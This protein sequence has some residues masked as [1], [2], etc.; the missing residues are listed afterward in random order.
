MQYKDQAL[1]SRDL[2]TID[3]HAPVDFDPDRLKT[4][5]PD[6]EA[7][8]QLFAELEFRQ[9][10]HEYTPQDQSVERRYAAILDAAG[11]DELV[12]RLE[13]SMRFALDTETTALDPM[14]ARLVGLSFC[15]SPG[16]AWYLPVGHNYLGAPKQLSLETVLARLRPVMV[17]PNIEKIGQNIKY[18]WMVLRRHGLDLAA[19]TFDTMVASY[20]IDP[21]K[22][23]HGLDQ[24]A[25]DYLG[26]KNITYAEVAGKGKAAVTFDQVILEK[27]IPYACEDADMT[28]AAHDVFV[29]LLEE[30]GLTELM[31][32]VEM[33]LL[34]VL[35]AMEMTGVCVDRKRLRDLSKSFAGQLDILEGQI[36]GLAGETFNINSSQQ[37][38]HILFEK[39]NLPVQKRPR[40]RP[41]TPP[42]WRCSRPWPAVTNY[43]PWCCATGPWPSSN[44]PMP[45][46]CWN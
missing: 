31:K 9:L 14:Q 1:L 28:L 35:L 23:A 17:N 18:D 11:L 46:P 30:N 32:Q 8:T 45:M 5:G 16:E 33:P 24:I 2:V 13:G 44:Q 10:Q 42:T 43:R 40:K 29:P 7:L 26:H 25:L 37:L 41:A 3:T 38:G 20:L 19:V 15:L 21:G 34:P 27:A 22:R 6:D 12:R 36:H 39:L 4:Q